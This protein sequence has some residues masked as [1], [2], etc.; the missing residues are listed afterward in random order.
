MTPVVTAIVIL[1]LALTVA[2]GIVFGL[3]TTG[4]ILLGLIAACGALAVSIARKARAGTVQPDV[5]PSCRGFN[6]PNAPYC[7][8]CGTHLVRDRGPSI[9]APPER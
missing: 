4:L 9:P 8:H 6:S 1:G 3:D 7:K 2:L 5:C